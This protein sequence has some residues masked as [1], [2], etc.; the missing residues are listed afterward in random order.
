MLGCT[1]SDLITIY[2][3]P[4]SATF[5][6]NPSQGR[7]ILRNPLILD[8]YLSHSSA[9]FS[10]PWAGSR[11]LLVH[12]QMFTDGTTT[13]SCDTLVAG[14]VLQSTPIDW[15]CLYWIHRDTDPSIYSGSIPDP[16]GPGS[17]AKGHC[18]YTL[19]TFVLF[20]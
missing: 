2:Y 4:L 16:F 6:Q 5:Y 9:A 3:P 11:H 10:L 12:T 17:H 19:S 13:Y 14:L 1:G 15:W 8:L 18:L 7:I 20:A